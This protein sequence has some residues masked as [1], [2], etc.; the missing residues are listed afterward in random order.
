MKTGD[1]DDKFRNY[2]SPI[3]ESQMDSYILNCR[4]IKKKKQNHHT[5][6]LAL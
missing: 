3:F 5:I 6:S 1:K 4:A 2:F